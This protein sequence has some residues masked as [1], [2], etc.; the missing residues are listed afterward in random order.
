MCTTS[1][2]RS[3][4]APRWIRRDFAGRIR[5]LDHHLGDRLCLSRR[6][7]VARGWPRHRYRAVA[8][9]RLRQRAGISPDGC[10]DRGK[11]RSAHDHARAGC[12]IRSAGGTT[13]PQASSAA[14]RFAPVRAPCRYVAAAAYRI[15]ERRGSPAMVGVAASSRAIALCRR[16][17]AIE[18]SSC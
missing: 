12:A 10:A 17:R 2:S 3:R 1:S 4:R 9:A 18:R 13:H 6:N 8:F 15:P 11:Q 16:I 5:P 14:V 7:L